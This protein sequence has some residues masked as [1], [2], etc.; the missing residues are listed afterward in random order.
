M[1][2]AQDVTKPIHF[3]P[4]K[5]GA[6]VRGT[7]DGR[8]GILYTLGA[9]AGQTLAVALKSRSTSVSFNVYA[10][11]KGPGDEAMAIGEMLD[12][13]NRFKGVLPA[14]GTYTISVFLNR[15][16]ARRGARAM[17]T[18]D[19]SIPGSAK[20][21][22]GPVT[23]DFADGLQGGPDTWV[24]TGVR[25]GDVLNLRKGPSARDPVVASRPE[26][27][28]LRNGGC[29][30]VGGQRWCRVSTTD[31]TPVEG[32]VAGRYLREGGAEG[33]PP[34]D[35][36]LADNCRRY[37]AVDFGTKPDRIR[38]AGTR[39]GP[40]GL[41]VDATADLGPQG[42]KPFACRFRKDGLYLGIMSKV[43]E[44]KL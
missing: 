3:A 23:N 18:L 20:P 12:P 14:S 27:A 25:A 44:G 21:A 33:G 39:P 16:A 15:A 17:F 10:P 24:V 43:D 41:L 37:A 7:V 9:E 5:D 6:T 42:V 30:M 40:E 35:A 31:G 13:I 19:V 2:Q 28:V 36:V 8:S 32:W 34:P 38:T 22:A 4:G 29:R 26:G 11:G 1:A